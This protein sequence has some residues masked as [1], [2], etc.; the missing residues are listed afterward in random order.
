MGKMACQRIS[1]HH[2]VCGTAAAE[3]RTVRVDDVDAWP[4]HIAC[5][6]DSKSEVVVPIEVGGVVVAVID[7]DCAAKHGIG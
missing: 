7:I 4:G 5:D 6:E 2:G 1:Y 3:K